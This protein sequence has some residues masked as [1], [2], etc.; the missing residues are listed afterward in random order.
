M[1]ETICATNP[2]EINHFLLSR[3]TDVPRSGSSPLKVH[4][5]SNWPLK[6]EWL[7]QQM[8]L[9][10]VGY[11]LPPKPKILFCF[12][13]CAVHTCVVHM[14]THAGGD[15]RLELDVSF[16]CTPLYFL[17]QTLSLNQNSS[18]LAS[19]ARQ[20]AQLALSPS[21]TDSITR[22]PPWPT[23]FMQVLGI[24][25]QSSHLCSK[26]FTHWAISL[27]HKNLSQLIVTFMIILYHIL[28]GRTEYSKNDLKKTRNTLIMATT[29][30]KMRY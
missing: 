28:K 22:G 25:L 20:V 13:M 10:I 30:N 18:F 16:N 7:R 29:R 8:H 3:S 6:C 17:K 15:P 5:F 9:S 4:R 24:Q 27:A 2:M 11:F 23:S 19:P 12:C 21:L 14:C 1:T 26:R